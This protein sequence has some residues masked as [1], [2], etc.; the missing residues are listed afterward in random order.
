MFT[1]LVFVVCLQ[2]QN[3]KNK[4]S[5]VR[6]IQ[7]QKERKKAI[8]IMDSQCGWFYGNSNNIENIYNQFKD[9]IEIEIMAGGLLLGTNAT[10]GSVELNRFIANKAPQMEKATEVTIG[11][12]IY[13]RLKDNS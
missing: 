12:K 5:E 11:K 3:S 7:S 10:K 8:Y 2:S 4:T 6:N 9:D 1:L 13:E